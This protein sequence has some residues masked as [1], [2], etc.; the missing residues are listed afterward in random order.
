M[1][2]GRTAAGQFALSHRLPT[3]WAEGEPAPGS[4][5]HRQMQN[6]FPLLRRFMSSDDAQDLVEYAFLAAFVGVAGYLTLGTIGGAVFATYSSWI[7]PD[8]GVPSLW[9]PSPPLISS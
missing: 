5:G 7:D 4:N 3:T 9:D 2:K 6:T 8:A 1:E